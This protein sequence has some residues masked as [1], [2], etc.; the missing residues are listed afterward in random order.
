MDA[1]RKRGGVS[2]SGVRGLKE[3]D[4]LAPASLVL[5]LSRSQRRRRRG[6]SGDGDMEPGILGTLEQ[7]RNS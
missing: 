5:S 4:E 6:E 7:I 3:H 2:P 1:V